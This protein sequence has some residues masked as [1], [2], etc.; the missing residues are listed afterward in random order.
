MTT[1]I[2]V[3]MFNFLQQIMTP[4]FPSQQMSRTVAV[5]LWVILHQILCQYIVRCNTEYLVSFLL[6]L[7]HLHSPLGVLPPTFPQH[8][9]CVHFIMQYSEV[10]VNLEIHTYCTANKI[11]FFSQ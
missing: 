3:E 9:P 5:Q 1:Y 6:S 2:R 8:L 7:L 4:I 11:S 10:N